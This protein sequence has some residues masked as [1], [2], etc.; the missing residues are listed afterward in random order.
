MIASY[1][2]VFLAM[3]YWLVRH[4]RLPVGTR[5]G[6]LWVAEAVQRPSPGD[7]IA[8]AETLAYNEGAPAAQLPLLPLPDVPLRW[9]MRLVGPQRSLW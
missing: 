3:P 5:V 6:D 8:L 1:T 2:G 7:Q 4:D 9:W